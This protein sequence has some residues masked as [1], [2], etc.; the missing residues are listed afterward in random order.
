MTAMISSGVPSIHDYLHQR[1][2][3]PWLVG[4][5]N[6][7]FWQVVSD[8]SDT[9]QRLPSP[10]TVLIAEA[11]PLILLA[12]FFA[13]AS[14]GWEL[15]L[16]NPG[17]GSWEWQQVADW[18]TPDLVWGEVILTEKFPSGSKFVG[19]GRLQ[20]PHPPSLE[21]P[22]VPSA[23]IHIPTGGSSGQVKF[24]THSWSTL[25]A[26]VLGFQQYFQADAVNTYCVLP[27]Y[28]VSGLMQALRS[29]TSGGKLAIQPF[30]SLEFEMPLVDNPAGWFLSL[31]PTQLQRLMDRG[32]PV[33]DWL[34]P[35]Q[36]VLLGGAPA[37]PAL[38]QAARALHL[39]IALTYGMTETASQVVTLKPE[40]FLAGIIASGRCLPHA[41]VD[42]LNDEGMPL[43]PGKPGQIRI[44]GSSVM[45]GYYAGESSL[46]IALS[47]P[48]T[49][50]ETE[51][52]HTPDDIGYLD[53]D[54]YLH[55]IGR[56][57]TKIITGGENVF[58][59][60]VEAVIRATGLV[61]DVAVLGWPDDRWGQMVIAVYVSKTHAAHQI[62]A[63]LADQLSRYKHPKRWIPVAGLPRNA[64]GKLNRP[65]L[66]AILAASGQ[67]ASL[68]TPD[69]SLGQ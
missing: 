24:A 10:G 5:D 52:V 40:D 36:A 19:K 47:A 2:G 59:E 13:A 64:Q 25:M 12:S 6:Q 11:D 53:A 23:P 50:H 51:R 62:Q 37:W 14:V 60:E 38:L 35:Y 31:V 30:K 27:L 26:S 41:S 63:A 44:R 61:E 1:W 9:L 8:R 7:Q 15:F 56:N 17:W 16:C 32:I 55:I 66:Q 34:R 67:V 28:H 49:I 45:G 46:P 39:P 4:L 3:Q 48:P 21:K 42:I 20:C 57:S 43:P 69:G 54:G 29:L 58:P 65:R 22:E 68:P 33:T 18:I